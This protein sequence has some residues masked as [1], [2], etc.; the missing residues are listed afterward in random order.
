[1]INEVTQSTPLKG[2]WETTEF[3][4][5]SF[6]DLR[7]DGE[8][9]L[10]KTETFPERIIAVLNP[11]N[12]DAALKALL[13][14]FP[15]VEAK[16][17]EL[18]Q[19]WDST[20]D[21]LKLMGK[22]SRL[23]DYLLHTNAIG[24]FDQLHRKIISWEAR[25]EELV[26][27]NYRTRL[28]LVEK[29]EQLAANSESWKEDTQKLKELGDQWKAIGFID[30]HRNDDLWN[31]LENARNKFFE[32]KRQ[33]QEEQ[34]KELLRNLD[35]KMEIVEKAE[36]L[37]ESENWKEVTEIFR[38]L[39]DQ[40]KSV[41]RTIHE[42]NEELW[43]RFILAKNRF[44][45]RKRIHFES[46]QAEQ[47]ENYIHKLA[48][49]EQAEALKDSRDWNKTSQAFA[50]IM[51]S[52]K[53]IGKVPLEKADELWARMNAAKEIFF[54]NKR[55]HLESVR[56]SQEDNYAQKFALLKRAEAIK[57]S[58]NWRETTEEMNELL[59]E[60]KKI[61]PVP[62]EHMQTLWEQF[63][64]ARK[65]FFN[66]KDDDREKR[67]QFVEK[68]IQNKYSKTRSFLEQLEQELQEE[69]TR[70]EDFRNALENVTPGNKEEELRTHLEKLI[71]QTEHK[72]R[73]KEE[74]VA[75]VRK[76]VADLEKMNRPGNK[77]EEAAVIPQPEA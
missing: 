20:P 62:R 4:G 42:K 5:K 41:G 39:M 48:L 19:E 10:K 73:H 30:K 32:R 56:V 70:L 68:Q 9:V 45:E 27:Q 21:K 25:L 31:R 38:Q 75:D 72:I 51:D 43:N 12:A 7:E 17:R 49:V 28:E 23:R 44:Y 24:D 13:E 77:E 29:A 71:A 16:L 33:H 26:E 37:A 40:W 58:S 3:P 69:R 34:E 67:K 53:S 74:K 14:K 64:A 36:G 52:W 57:N 55:Q 76:Q 59:T 60:W 63:L 18:E 2:W 15:E 65:H 35:L 50:E 54:T 66:R 22:V 61:G 11:D 6:C 47:E 8:L 46:I 1:M